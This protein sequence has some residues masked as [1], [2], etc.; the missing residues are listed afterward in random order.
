MEMDMSQLTQRINQDLP[1][2]NLTVTGV[3][4]GIILGALMNFGSD[5]AEGRIDDLGDEV[6][7]EYENLFR[8]VM[9]AVTTRR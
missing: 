6:F 7:E 1:Q 8:S 9:D 3:Q 2:V 4:A 5:V